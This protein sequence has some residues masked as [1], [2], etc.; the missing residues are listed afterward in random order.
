[1]VWAAYFA[2]ECSPRSVRD[3]KSTRFECVGIRLQLSH[4]LL[5]GRENQ[6]TSIYILYILSVKNCLSYY[7]C[8]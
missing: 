4:H 2:S 1:M 3:A 5:D 8:A 6:E 7:M